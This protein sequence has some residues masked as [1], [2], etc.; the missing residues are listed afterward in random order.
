MRG[1]IAARPGTYRPRPLIAF[2]TVGALAAAVHLG[3]VGLLVPAGLHPL[4]ANVIAFLT[5]FGVSFSG[6]RRWTFP[7][8]GRPRPGPLPRFFAVAL[9]AFVLNEGLYA[10]I[11]ASGLL[12]YREALVVVL[13][14]VAAITFVASKYWAFTDERS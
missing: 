14:I 4:V 7:T 8:T 2:G 6:H 3:V 11:L 5:A 13:V 1:S 10:L 9:M 12:G